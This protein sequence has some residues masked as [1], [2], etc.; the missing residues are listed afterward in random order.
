MVELLSKWAKSSK[1]KNRSASLPVELWQSFF[2]DAAT[3]ESPAH[4][5]TS[6]FETIRWKNRVS[7]RNF[8]FFN[9]ARGRDNFGRH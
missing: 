9:T 8:L 3:G 7:N 5:K 2:S 6:S 4:F 1:K